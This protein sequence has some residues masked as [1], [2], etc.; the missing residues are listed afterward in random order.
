M[1]LSLKQS[2][3]ELRLIR[4]A[5]NHAPTRFQ[6]SQAIIYIYSPNRIVVSL[7]CPPVI[8]RGKCNK[9]HALPIPGQLSHRAAFDHV[10]TATADL[11]VA[12]P[13]FMSKINIL[14]IRE[15]I[16][17]F[18]AETFTTVISHEFSTTTETAP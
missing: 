6:L 3:H 16:L 15:E 9:V 1:L 14:Q 11:D 10:V 17:Q 13:A 18:N 4:L 5:P 12:R 7:L 8:S 2:I